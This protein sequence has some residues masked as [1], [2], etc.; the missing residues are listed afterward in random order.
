[1]TSPAAATDTATAKKRRPCGEPAINE[2]FGDIDCEGTTSCDAAPGFDGPSGVG[3]PIGLRAF[4]GPS[5]AK[6]TVVTEAASSVDGDL[7]GAERHG[8]PERRSGKH[9]HVRIRADDRL[10]P[11]RAV[12]VAAGVWDEPGRGVRGD[13]GPRPRRRIYHFRIS[14]TNASGTSTGKDKKLKTS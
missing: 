5:Q 4:D 2:E 1:M 12:L 6:P 11:Q 9:V 8:E 13:H 10:W 14:A 7:G 3:T